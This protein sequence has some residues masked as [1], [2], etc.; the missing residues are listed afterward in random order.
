MTLE[1]DRN[2]VDYLLIGVMV[3]GLALA[4]ASMFGAGMS[5]SVAGM[6]VSA[7]TLFRPVVLAARSRS[8]SLY[9]APSGASD[10]SHSCGPWPSVTRR[11]IAVGMAVVIFAVAMR[12]SLFEARASD[13]WGY[14]SQAALWARGDLVIRS[15][16][17]RQP[18]GL[19]RP[20]HLRRSATVPVNV[21]RPSCRRILLGCH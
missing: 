11:H 14:V 16:S 10:N 15:R 13:Q 18:R 1:R 3:L 7:R 4:V 21:R 2:P 8:H 17:R 6:R 5:T 9:G 19:T 12:M 20:G